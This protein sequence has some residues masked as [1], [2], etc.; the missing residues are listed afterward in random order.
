MATIENESFDLKCPNE[1]CGKSISVRNRDL[2]SSRKAKCQ[3]CG[4]EIVVDSSAAGEL[5]RA[6]REVDK[7]EEKVSNAQ[8]KIL[9]RAQIKLGR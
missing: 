5:M 9:T 4:T 8:S 7:A 6:M 2:V 3:R 1:K